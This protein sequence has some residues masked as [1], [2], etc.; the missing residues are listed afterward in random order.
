MK[1]FKIFKNHLKDHDLF[2]HAVV[3][4]FNRGGD[5]HKTIIGGFFSLFVKL[6]ML[7]YIMLNVMKLVTFDDDKINLTV[8]KL[9]LDE[10]GALDYNGSHQLFFWSLKNTQGGNSPIFLDN[11]Y[12][13]PSDK[14]IKPYINV[15]FLQEKVN[16]YNFEST[17][18]SKKMYEHIK[19]P[20]KQCT[21]EDFCF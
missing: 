11:E 1:Q 8:K 2:G 12:L 17:D 7:F 9:D 13:K 16:W 5:T 14:S 19:V 15:G 6:G 20:A 3:L 4:N 18:P 21:Q 10:E